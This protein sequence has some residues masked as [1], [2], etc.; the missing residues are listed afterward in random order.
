MSPIITS[1]TTSSQ[2]R[3]HHRNNTAEYKYPDM[4]DDNSDE[5]GNH[6]RGIKALGKSNNTSKGGYARLDRDVKDHQN[7]L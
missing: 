1:T 3:S 7:D 2:E 6:D 4:P 5:E